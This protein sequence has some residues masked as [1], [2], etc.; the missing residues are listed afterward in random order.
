MK[1]ELKKLS[2]KESKSNVFMTLGCD[3]NCDCKGG[4]GIDAIGNGAGRLATYT[5]GI[6]SKN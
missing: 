6:W 2:N 1:H 3:C 5:V 4:N